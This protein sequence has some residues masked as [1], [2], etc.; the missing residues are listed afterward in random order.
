MLIQWINTALRQIPT[1][2]LYLI[3]PI[4]GLLA[5]FQL[6]AGSWSVKVIRTMDLIDLNPYF[7]GTTNRMGAPF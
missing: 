6:V 3:L 1:W 7:Q 4:P 5:I 2:V